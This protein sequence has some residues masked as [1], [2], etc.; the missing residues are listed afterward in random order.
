M[1][2]LYLFVLMQ[3]HHRGEHSLL[4]VPNTDAALRTTPGARI[5]ASPLAAHGHAAAVT[6]TAIA[7]DIHQPLDVQRN[8]SSKVTFN[9]VFLI[10]DLAEAV[11]LI[12]GQIA[13]TR[14]RVDPGPLEQDPAGVGADA[15]DIRKRSLN[16]LLARKVDSGNSRH[17]ARSS[18]ARTERLALTLLMLGIR[19]DHPDNS[20]PPNHLAFVASP[21]N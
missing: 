21:L 5:G 20:V 18:N 7:A 19:A 14:V 16:P 11:D 9:A 6:Q 15:I 2:L 17:I 13:H 8:L 4:L 3:A 1:V 10:D 12:V